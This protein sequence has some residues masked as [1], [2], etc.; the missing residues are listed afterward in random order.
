M[1]VELKSEIEM[2]PE[3]RKGLRVLKEEYIISLQAIF[4]PFVSYTTV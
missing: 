1:L 2:I 3:A 4:F